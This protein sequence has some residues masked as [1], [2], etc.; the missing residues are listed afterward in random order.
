[1]HSFA[2]S[3]HYVVLAE[4]P[5]VADAQALAARKWPFIENYEWLPERGTIFTVVSKADGT[6]LDKAH[7]RGSTVR[8]SAV[9]SARAL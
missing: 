1:M 6:V 2:M 7:G 5:L 9:C 4:Y 3:E 8:T